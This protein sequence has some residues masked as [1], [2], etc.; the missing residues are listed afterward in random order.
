M[1]INSVVISSTRSAVRCCGSQGFTTFHFAV[2][3]ADL[4]QREKD[5]RRHEHW[6]DG[7]SPSRGDRAS[8]H[9]P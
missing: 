4:R 6:P 9:V 5:L 7:R 3:H 2:I 1:R 8:M